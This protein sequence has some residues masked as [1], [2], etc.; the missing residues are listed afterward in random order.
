MLP[1]IFRKFVTEL[2]P[3]I[4]VRILLPL[5]ILRT[6]Q[7]TFAKFYTCIH[8]D[9]IY[10]GF[11]HVAVIFCLFVTELWPLIYV[12]IL[13][14]LNIFRTNEH[15]FTKLYIYIYIGKSRFGILPAIFRKYVTELWP[16]I[17]VR[18]SFLLNILRSNQQTFTKCYTCINFDKIYVGFV[19]YTCHFFIICNRAMALDLCQNFV[20]A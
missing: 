20:S 19:T 9:K 6:N 3:L 18:I 16:L 4:G 1:V 11:L 8:F 2:C 5:N 7:Q 12:R 17:D 13:F 14:P 15:N 10:V